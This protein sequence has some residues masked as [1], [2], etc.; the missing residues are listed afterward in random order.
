MSPLTPRARHRL[1]RV[2]LVLGAIAILGLLMTAA[3]A[4]AGANS[5]QLLIRIICLAQFPTSQPPRG[6]FA[7]YAPGTSS[8]GT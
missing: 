3:D 1:D 5:P 8:C 7:A 6:A 2:L 4:A